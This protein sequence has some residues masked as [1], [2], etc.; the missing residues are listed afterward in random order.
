MTL[1]FIFS[2]IYNVEN[3]I[4]HENLVRYATPHTWLAHNL[5]MLA[6]TVSRLDEHTALKMIKNKK[7]QTKIT[8]TP[9]ATHCYCCTF[10]TNTR[11][12]LLQ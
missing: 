12:N 6:I 7:Q 2:N 11:L 4:Q 10:K 1:H 9:S 5:V 3:N 8:Q